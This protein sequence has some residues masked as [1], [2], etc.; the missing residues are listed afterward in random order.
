MKSITDQIISRIK[1][2]KP[3]WVFTPKD[4][5]DVGSRAAIDQVLS[6]LVKQDM[7]RRLD[8][9]VYDYPK[10]HPKL[11]TLSPDYDDLAR[12]LA[13]GDL[14]FPSG[15]VA[16]NTLGL[17]TQVPAKSFYV[18]NSTVRSRCIAG[19]TIKLKRARVALLDNVHDKTNFVLQA[20]SYLRK[21][22]MD[23]QVIQRCVRVLSD[24]D[25]KDLNKA[26]HRIPS[27]MADTLHK[28]QREKSS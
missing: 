21:T 13:G 18:T 14:V 28:I 9:G 25:M 7:V 11:G 4:F 10:Q 15:A 5:L 23:D 6:R 20:L 22:N 27:W 3:G 26:M 16:A 2:R 1:R 17:S 12:A 8:R 19:Q 24:S